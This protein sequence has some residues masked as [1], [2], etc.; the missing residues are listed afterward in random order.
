MRAEALSLPDS[1]RDE[2]ARV[3]QRAYKNPEV[4]LRDVRK[5]SFSAG[6]L[7]AMAPNTPLNTIGDVEDALSNSFN[8]ALISFANTRQT[9]SQSFSQIVSGAIVGYQREDGSWSGGLKQAVLDWDGTHSLKL[10]VM[11]RM[12]AGSDGAKR[13]KQAS[14]EGPSLFEDEDG[15]ENRLVQEEDVFPSLGGNPDA[16]P[17]AVVFGQSAEKPAQKVWYDN[18]E[19]LS[20]GGHTKTEFTFPHQSRSSVASPVK[21]LASERMDGSSGFNDANYESPTPNQSNSSYPTSLYLPAGSSYDPS[22]PRKKDPGFLL[23]TKMSRRDT[24]SNGG[25]NSEI[26]F[27]SPQRKLVVDGKINPLAIAR[28]KD[29]G[30]PSGYEQASITPNEISELVSTTLDPYY[31]ND[32]RA[33]LSSVKKGKRGSPQ[34]AQYEA[35]QKRLSEIKK[36][37]GMDT[38]TFGVLEK[39]LKRL[40]SG[41]EANVT[42]GGNPI[43]YN[44]QALDEKF[45]SIPE[46]QESIPVNEMWSAVNS[47]RRSGDKNYRKMEARAVELTKAHFQ[48]PNTER[49]ATPDKV[50]LEGV[51]ELIGDGDEGIREITG[52]P[53]IDGLQRSSSSNGETTNVV[54]DISAREAAI[55]SVSERVKNSVVEEAPKSLD[56][57]VRDYNK[58]KEVDQTEQT[59]SPQL[60]L[61]GDPK[62]VARRMLA[63]LR[64]GKSEG[65]GFTGR[66]EDSVDQIADDIGRDER[67]KR[68]QQV[69]GYIPDSGLELEDE[70]TPSYDK[71]EKSFQDVAPK[72]IKDIEQDPNGIL[73]S[74]L[75]KKIA[76]SRRFGKDAVKNQQF[77]IRMQYRKKAASE[78]VKSK[79]LS[80]ADNGKTGPVVSGGAEDEIKVAQKEVDRIMSTPIEDANPKFQLNVAKK[81]WSL[82]MRNAESFRNWENAQK[83]KKANAQSVQAAPQAARQDNIPEDPR[84]SRVDQVE[85]PVSGVGNSVNAPVGKQELLSGRR[86]PSHSFTEDGLVKPDGYQVSHNKTGVGASVDHE[87]KIVNYDMDALKTAYD[88]K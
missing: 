4:P 9:D 27:S 66:R 6:P 57:L 74:K 14:A 71:D 82:G 75:G 26:S 73:D 46:E 42:T 83:G 12:S 16:S 79:G 23:T 58:E 28:T 68:L 86:F 7:Q 34:R 41:L 19:K 67:L 8:N 53:E 40:S 61:Q 54:S 13:E 11:N 47:A 21:S 87:S 69:P 52:V 85:A 31:K 56:D 25:S 50:D 49:S 51:K 18:L 17:N 44:M 45:L 60:T 30:I 63:D 72:I 77:G 32:E 62:E 5:Q 38:E 24:F 20:R 59:D 35:A 48:K 2:F 36:N 55:R 88:N 3:I 70:Y 15:S 80:I 33:S 84:E 10:H 39:D 64:K 76:R 1:T 78:Y 29:R 22:K 37:L 81:Q 65:T 43:G